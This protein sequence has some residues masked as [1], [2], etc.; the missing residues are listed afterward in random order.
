MAHA[1]DQSLEL[2]A[3]T[4]DESVNPGAATLLAAVLMEPEYFAG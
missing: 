3:I 4:F 1:D 2:W